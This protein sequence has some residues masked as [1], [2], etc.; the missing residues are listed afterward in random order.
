MWGL[1]KDYISIYINAI[2]LVDYVT[3]TAQPKMN[4]EKMNSILIAVP[5]KE[6]QIRIIRRFKE[7]LPKVEEYGKAQDRLDELNVQLPEKLKASILQEAIEG[8]LVPQNPDDEPATVLLDKIE[9]EKAALVKAKKIKPDKNASRIYRTDDGRWFEHFTARKAPDIDITEEV[10][11]DIPESWK[12]VRL[13]Y[14]LQL[15]DGEKKEGNHIVLD[16]KY[17]R[18]KSQEK[19]I[20][21]GKFVHKGDD[22]I[23][24]DGE[25]S[26]EVFSVPT[27][28]YMGSTFK[29]LWL[30]KVLDK[31]FII[32]NLL[33]Y[34]EY[35]RKN[36][37]GAAIPHLNKE[38]FYD[39]IVGIPPVNEQHRIVEK[40]ETIL[41]LINN[42]N[43]SANESLCEI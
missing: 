5:P 22:I 42:I 41:T 14:I 18:G 3:G 19:H 34:K 8:R 35:L 6:E 43:T 21:Q 9:K 10:P 24:V 16:A 15:I 32:Y 20:S 26:G 28:G 25:N 30:T 23:L 37:K 31:Q 36:K 2:S 38:I 12:F 1:E 33:I 13:S 17:L 29:Q 7:F 40:L 4:Q 11:Y 39:I 27:D